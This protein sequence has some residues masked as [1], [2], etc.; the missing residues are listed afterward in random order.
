[1]TNS[2]IVLL[3]DCIATGQSLLW[4]EISG[5]KD[6]VA[7]AV[8]C[9]ENKT[10]E[11][12]LVAWYLKNR[13]EKLQINSVIHQSLKAKINKEKS[14]SWVAHIPG[15][16]N[17]AVAGETFQGMH[18][19]IKKII[20]ENKKPSLVLITC[21]AASHRCVVINQNNQ[22]FVVKR[23]VALLEKEQR[24]WPDEVYKEYVSRVR[25]QELYGEEFQKRKN[26]KSFTM[27]IKLLDQSR[28]PY[29]FLLFRKYN[30]YISD[31]FVDLSDLIATYSNNGHEQLTRKLEAQPEIAKRVM[32]N[33]Q[34]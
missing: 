8:D 7:D 11:K 26:K 3:G 1:M 21:F 5:D 17:L 6:F 20:T 24:I 30:R 31:Q 32:S 27:L 33:I 16:L 34:P 18:K 22:K 23:E 10:L 2:Q 29:K 19:K 12:K 4:P 9:V 13:K 25:K 15:C 14:M 28:I